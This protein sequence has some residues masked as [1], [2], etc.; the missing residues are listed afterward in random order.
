VK[1]VQADVGTILGKL[2]YDKALGGLLKPL[3][4]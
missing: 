2:G 1:F 3:G 4:A